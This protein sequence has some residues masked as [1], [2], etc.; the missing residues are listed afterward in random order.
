MTVASVFLYR[1]SCVAPPWLERQDF[2]RQLSVLRCAVR[3]LIVSCLLLFGACCATLAAPAADQAEIQSLYRL[4]LA[5]DKAA[6][7]ACIEKLE[8]VLRTESSNQLARVYLGSAYTLQSRDLGFG[9]KKLQVLRKGVAVMDEAVAAAPG[10]PKV[11]LARALTT[12]ALPAILGYRAASRKDF[13]ALAEMARR[14]PEK[15]ERGDL[16]IVYYNAGLSA[17]EA[18]DMPRAV[19]LW[20]QALQHSADRALTEKVKA[21]LAR[22]K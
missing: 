15:F 14:T 3:A 12:S 16:Q 5:G 11:R 9:P 17:K 20:E 8:A 22:A 19:G 4:G 7:A 18:G 6:V 2:A 13:D 21:E 10:D 1:A